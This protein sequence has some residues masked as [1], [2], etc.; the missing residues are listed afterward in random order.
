VGLAHEGIDLALD[1]ENLLDAKWYD[2]E[3]V[4][5]SRFTAESSAVPQRHVS[6]G[7]PRTVMVTLTLRP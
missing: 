4:Y 5:S 1:I 2:G 3:F 6:V 7:A